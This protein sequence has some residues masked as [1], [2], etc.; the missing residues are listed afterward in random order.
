MYVYTD[1]QIQGE[2]FELNLEGQ[3]LNI[4]KLMEAISNNELHCMSSNL[5]NFVLKH[6]QGYTDNTLNKIKFVRK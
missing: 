5:F 4:N 2:F 3:N 1:V 6:P